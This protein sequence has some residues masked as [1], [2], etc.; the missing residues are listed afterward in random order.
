MKLSQTCLVSKIMTNIAIF[1][2]LSTKVFNPLFIQIVKIP[3]TLGC[4]PMVNSA[5][6]II[7]NDGS[8]NP[9]LYPHLVQIL[10]HNWNMQHLRG[11]S[12]ALEPLL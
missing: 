6:I 3:M 11:S 5:V 1:L 4:N 2:E 12:S 9:L 7:R 10:I 8:T